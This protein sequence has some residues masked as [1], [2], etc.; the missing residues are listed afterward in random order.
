ELMYAT[1]INTAEANAIEFTVVDRT[2]D[3]IPETFRYAWSGT[4]GDPVTRQ[5]N[6]GA[7]QTV[8]EN[9][10]TF[11]LTYHGP[12]ATEEQP[13]EGESGEQL[14]AYFTPMGSSGLA[15][16]ETN[17]PGQYFEP[18]LPANA[19]GWRITQVAFWASSNWPPDGEVAV[20]IRSAA[21]D[22]LPTDTVLATANLPA[23]SLDWMSYV[24]QRV[25]FSAM[26]ELSPDDGACLIIRQVSGSQ[27][28]NVLIEMGGMGTASGPQSFLMTTNGGG[29]W[30]ANGTINLDF[31]VYGTYT[32]PDILQTVTVVTTRNVTLTVQVGD[33]SGSA[34]HGGTRLVNEPKATIP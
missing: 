4:A 14:L 1:T 29:S 3:A 16:T 15:V 22:N 30:S 24:Y 12:T 9:V 27:P 21:A 25:S 6:G 34:I 28:C 19:T 13:G 5:V 8:L 11:D 26:G 2:G 31:A 23:S 10:H 18:T 32:A 17:W 33:E 7:V 20:Q